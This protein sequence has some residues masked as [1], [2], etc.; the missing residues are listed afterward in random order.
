MASMLDNSS[1]PLLALGVAASGRLAYHTMGYYLLRPGATYQDLRLQ[2]TVLQGDVDVYVSAD[3]DS[4]P[5]FSSVRGRVESFLLSG[6]SSGSED[7]TI[8]HRWVQDTAC[9]ERASC[10]LVVG[11]HS[12]YGSEGSFSQYS[13]LASTQDS[14]TILVN[15][16]P[17]QSHVNR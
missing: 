13:L 10:Y 2:A 9:A 1:A 6:V 8:S 12:S 5:V 11:V 4:R 7:F 16:V 17:R 14:T 15:G 3:W